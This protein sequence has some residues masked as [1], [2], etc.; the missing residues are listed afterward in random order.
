[1]Q[2]LFHTREN[3]LTL[4]EATYKQVDFANGIF[5]NLKK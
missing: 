3:R 1:M 4:Q 2:R 5:H